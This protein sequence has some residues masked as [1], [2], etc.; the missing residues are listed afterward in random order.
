MMFHFVHPETA[1]AAAAA[2]A[3]AE[4][5]RKVPPG[6]SLCPDGVLAIDDP[7]LTR[8]VKTEAFDNTDPQ[9]VE[10]VHRSSLWSNAQGW[11]PLKRFKEW[12]S[13]ATLRPKPETMSDQC[14]SE[15]VPNE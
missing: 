9:S 3:A 14:A 2:V 7:S 10:A 11:V 5:A 15:E 12:E 4:Q 1:A 6:F 8:V 13:E